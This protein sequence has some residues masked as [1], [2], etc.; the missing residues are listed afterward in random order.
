M[1]FPLS[2]HTHTHTKI[3]FKE[4]VWSASPQ[5]RAFICVRIFCRQHGYRDQAVTR[6]AKDRNKIILHPCAL[7]IVKCASIHLNGGTDST[8]KLTNLKIELTVLTA[9]T[10]ER[11]KGM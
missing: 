1:V 5:G 9:L 11:G 3:V 10:K 8:Q 7:S 4:V 2:P 6:I